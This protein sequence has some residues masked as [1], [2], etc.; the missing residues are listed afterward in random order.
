MGVRLFSNIYI[1]MKNIKT[2]V[3]IIG[4]LLLS[5]CTYTSQTL[6]NTWAIDQTGSQVD[7]TWTTHTGSQTDNTWV[8]DTGSQVGSWIIDV[9][10]SS[11]V[12]NVWKNER[13]DVSLMLTDGKWTMNIQYGTWATVNVHFESTGKKT[14]KVN[15]ETPLQPSA[16]IR[17]SYIMFPDKT[18]DGPFWK[19]VSYPLT[20]SGAYQ[21]VLSPSLMQWDMW[22]GTLIVNVELQ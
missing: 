2:N 9:T 13:K 16:N 20:Q 17:V 8:T 18:T 1:F 6:V 10:P 22:S 19:D 11:D 15:L 5:S 21:I 12:I 7:G 4:T 3:L 14:L